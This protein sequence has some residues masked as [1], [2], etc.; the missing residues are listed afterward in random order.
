MIMKWY[1]VSSHAER[2]LM[3]QMYNTIE[4]RRKMEY[5]IEIKNNLR[6]YWL[7]KKI[8]IRGRVGIP[9]NILWGIPLR[10]DFR[11][12]VYIS[13]STNNFKI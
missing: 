11:T 12:R 8:P 5:C 13:T 10:A 2:I 4:L 3:L 9:R 1:V 7:A 6:F